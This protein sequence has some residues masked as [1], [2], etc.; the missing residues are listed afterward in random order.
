[1]TVPDSKRDLATPK[2][3]DVHLEAR[4]PEFDPTLGIKVSA[5]AASKKQ[6][7]VAVGDSLTHG[8]QSGAIF[9]T[10][11]SYSA[12]I[13][14]E[15]G[16]SDQF[17]YPTYD[18]FGGLPF[19]IE[20]A[21]R[22]LEDRF[23]STL[24]WWELPLAYFALRN[25][26]AQSEHWW[27]YEGGAKVPNISYILDNLGIYG[28]DL[29]DALSVTADVCRKR[30]TSPKDSFFLPLIA[31][32]NDRAAQRVLPVAED[33]GNLSTI[34]AAKKLSDTSGGIETL[35]VML[36]AN[37]ALGTVT[38]LKVNWSQDS[39]YSSLDQKAKYTIWNPKHFQAE[40]EEVEKRIHEIDASHVIWATVPHVTIAPVA[41]GVAQKVEK[42][43]RYFP[44]Y[45]RP[46]ISD[47]Q[48]DPN[49]D[50]HITEN[51]ARAI[52]SAIDQYNDMITAV[53]RRARKGSAQV[54][55]KD[56]YLFDM[57]GLLD[58]LACR[59]YVED[60]AARPEWWSKYELPPELM[61]LDP[62]PDSRFFTSSEE[63][64]TAGGLF[65]LDGIHP[66]T[67]AYG[68][69]AQELINIMQ[70][71]GVPFVL[72]DGKTIRNGPVRIDF[73]RLIAADTLISNPPK[74]LKSDLKLIGWMDE[75]FD[76]F[77]K[78]LW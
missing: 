57:A 39:D 73:N 7:L 70:I 50:P 38:Q 43:S 32:A 75:T 28:W 33:N 16:W 5:G 63:G 67:I 58:R 51:Q 48:F 10:K 35:I 29:R 6:R 18:G 42:G 37:N 61:A 66:T 60:I 9:N 21:I 34:G 19:N 40:L 1:M 2:E 14:Y 36:G 44:Y 17:R 4:V 30:I 53:V 71:A 78:M 49:D 55:A 20:F 3:V 65:S 8:F 24:D 12:T 68:I 69:V 77:K 64:R 72:G 26:L 25:H 15:M 22:E 13:A 23:G 62:V 59:R 74:S 45:T 11:Y 56:W 46:W 27:E 47:S 41:R 52:D 76:V 31:N 54:P